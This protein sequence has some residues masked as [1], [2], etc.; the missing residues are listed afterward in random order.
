M[1]IPAS[2]DR[3][4]VSERFVSLQGEGVS[5]GAPAVFLRLGN[6][7]LSC[8]Y[9]DT[10]YT[11]DES[12]FD[13]K[14][15]MSPLEI[16]EV[17]AWIVAQ[18]QGRLIVTGGEPLLQHGRLVQLL[19]RLDRLHQE[20]SAEPLVIEIETNATIK[21]TATLL[22]RV[23]QWN[24]SPKL[25]FSG[26]SSARRLKPDVLCCFSE[27]SHAFFKFVVSSQADLDE[28]EAL[29]ASYGLNRSRVLLMPEATEPLALRERSPQVAGLA[30][31][32][33]LRFSSRL[34]LELYGGRRGT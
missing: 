16:D 21:P 12:R 13:L 26:E 30:L 14:V 28:V 34:H 19:A 24:V 33:G 32:A 10:P 15:E 25:S 27:L 20:S 11:W 17:A 9:C 5:A 23:D 7:N 3:L 18:N 29:I 4:L 1:G 8:S 31:R 6:C 22:A 2:G